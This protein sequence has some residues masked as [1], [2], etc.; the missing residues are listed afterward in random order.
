MVRT[1]GL[2]TQ[3]HRGGARCDKMRPPPRPGVQV[4]LSLSCTF[5]IEGCL[6]SEDPEG[7]RPLC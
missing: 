3:G 2:G 5:A 4:M 7:E 6:I 1:E